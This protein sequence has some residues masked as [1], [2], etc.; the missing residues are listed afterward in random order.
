MLRQLKRHKD[1]LFILVMAAFV[2]L[3]LLPP[4]PAGAVNCAS[5]GTDVVITV[6]CDFPAG[7]YTFTGT[8]T[9]NPGVTVTAL[10]NTGG[11]SG[12]II[13][14]DE[15]RIY[16]TLTAAGQGFTA[17]T[18][19]GAG[20]SGTGGTGAG[21]GGSGGTNTGGGSYGS[22]T[23]PTQLGSGGGSDTND[24]VT[25]ATG[26]G[27]IKLSIGAGTG[28]IVI[29]G[30]ISANGNNAGGAVST[31]AGPGS[32]GSIWIDAP[33]GTITGG[34]AI[35]AVGGNSQASG[36]GVGAGGG[37]IAL[38]YT[39]LSATGTQSANGGTFGSASSATFKS[40][41]AG[42][43]YRKAAA[44]ANG[45]VIYD[46]SN[47]TS[48]APTR[49][50]TTS[51][52]TYDNVTIKNGTNYFIP[53]TFTLNAVTS[54]TGGGTSMPSLTI[55]GTFGAPTA[56]TT[57]SGIDINHEGVVTTL[58]NPT[59][60]NGRYNLDTDTGTFTSGTANRMNDLTVGSGGYFFTE[61]LTKLFLNSLTVNSGGIVSHATNTTSKT[62]ILDVSATGSIT[63]NSGG[64]ISVNARGY[65]GGA[66]GVSGSGPGAGATGGFA[67]GGS[68]GGDGGT[69]SSTGPTGYDSVTAPDDLGS[70]G[71]GDNVSGVGG[72]GGGYVRLT[73]PSGQ[74]ITIA[75]SVTANG[76]NGSAADAGGGAGGTVHISAVGATV[77]GAGTITANGGNSP[78]IEGGG[79]GGGGR[80]AVYASTNSLSNAD[81]YNAAGGATGSGATSSNADGGA[82]SIYTK[83]DAASFGNLIVDNNNNDDPAPTTQVVTSSQTYINVTLKE[84]AEYVIPAT[85][86][87]VVA[88][89][90]FYTSGTVMP[91]LTVNGTFDAPAASMTFNGI[92]IFHNGT[93][94]VLTNPTVTNGR[95]TID[96][97]TSLFSAG[98]ANRVNNVTMGSG[99]F[100]VTSKLSKLFLSTLT[101]NSG[102][103]V[104]HATNTTAKTHILDVSASG[105]ITVNSGASVNVNERGYSGGTSSN[106]GN[107]PGFG[108]DG[109]FG[110]GASHGGNGGNGSVAGATAYDSVTAPS[111][112]GSG[113][114]GDDTGGTG[115]NG[116]GYVRLDAGDAATLTI[117]GS[118]TANGGNGSALDAAG[119]AGGTIHIIATGGTLTGAGTITANGGNSPTIEGGGGGG[120]GRIAV[121]AGTNSLSNGTPY[122]A[123][124]GATGS[125][126]VSTAGDGGAGSIYLKLDAATNGDLI[127]DNNNQGQSAITPQVVTLSQTY[128]NIII[129]E[130]A[131]YSLPNTFSLGLASG[132]TLTG[133]GTVRGSLAIANG[134]TFVGAATLNVLSVD[135]T[136]SGAFSTVTNLTLTGSNYTS[137]GTGT[138]STG[139]TSLT[140]SNATFNHGGTNPGLNLTTL[141]VPSGSTFNNNFNAYYPLSS[142][143]STLTVAGTFMHGSLNR[144]F[145]DTLTVNSGG[146]VTHATNTTTQAYALDI[147]ATTSI[148]V[149]SGGSINVNAKGYASSEGTGQGTDNGFEGQ[150]GGYGGDG[151]DSANLSSGGAAYGSVTQPVDL[152]SG[153]GADGNNATAGGAGGGAIKLTAPTVTIAGTVSTNGGNAEGTAGQ[154]GGGGSGGSIWVVATSSFTG[155]GTITANGGNAPTGTGNG[156][157]GGGGR[158]ALHYTGSLPSQTRQAFGGARGTATG[159]QKNGGA[160]T[161]Y[162][163]SNSQTN[164]DIIVDNNNVAGDFT[165][166]VATAAQTYDNIT[167]RN[168]SSYQVPS[169]FT[170]TLASGGALTAG[171]SVRPTMTVASGG[172]FNPTATTFNFN[173]IDVLNSGTIASVTTLTVT[174]GRFNHNAGANFSGGVASL[175]LASSAIWTDG[176][177]S[178]FNITSLTVPAGTSYTIANEKYYPFASNFGALSVAGTL[179]LQ[180]LA[181]FYVD[182]VTV[183]SGGL[184]THSGNT[185]SKQYVVDIS[186]TSTID[187]QS[188]GSINVDNLGY[189]SDNGTSPGISG[190]NSVAGGGAHGGNGGSVGGGSPIGAGGTAYDLVNQ[191]TDFGSGGGDD[192]L[193]PGANGGAGGG[194]IKLSAASGATVTIAGTVSANGQ[195]GQGTDSG[196]GAGGSIWINAPAATLAGTGTVRARGGSGIVGQASGGGGGGRVAIYYTSGNPYAYTLQIDGGVGGTQ[197]SQ[198]QSGGSG[199]IYLKSASQTNGDLYLD[200]NNRPN[201]VATPQL[202]STETYDKIRIRNLANY[203]IPSAFVFNVASGGTI[204]GG[205]TA[206]GVMTINSGATFNPPSATF[207]LEGLNVTHTGSFGTV[208]DLTVKNAVLTSAGSGFSA[209]LTAFTADTGG[210]YVSSSSS[211][212]LTASGTITVKSGGLL[213][214]ATN[215][216][217][218]HH[219]YSLNISANN[220]DIQSGGSVSVAGKG[221]SGSNGPGSGAPNGTTGGG[222][223]HGGAGGNGSTVGGGGGTYGSISQPVMPGSGGGNDTTSTTVSEGGS[224]GGVIKITLGAT[225]TLNGTLSANGNAGTGGTDMGGGGAGGSIW[226]DVGTATLNANVTA[227]GGVGGANGVPGGGGGGGGRIAA[228]YVVLTGS[229]TSTA[230]GG[231][232]GGSG[233]ATAGANGSLFNQL[234]S[235]IVLVTAPN[236]AESLTGSATTSVTFSSLGASIDHFRISLST[237][238]GSSFGTIITSTAT[239]SPYVWTI[240]NITTTQ[241]R[242]KVEGLDV[243][244]SAV[245]EDSSNADFSITAVST[246][247]P[248]PPAP[249]MTLLAPNGGN[250]FSSGQQT[251]ILWTSGGISSVALSYST[252][253]GSTYTQITSGLSPSA[254]SYTWTVPALS[255]TSTQTI[256]KADGGTVYDTSDAVFTINA[257]PTLSTQPS[258]TVTSPNGGETLSSG[259]TKTVTWTK[260]GTVGNLTL[261]YSKDGGATYAQIAAGISASAGSYAWNVPVESATATQALVRITDGT[262]TDVSDAVFTI[263]PSVSPEAQT[264]LGS[265]GLQAAPLTVAATD[266]GDQLSFSF[267]DEAKSELTTQLF[268]IQDAA[269]GQW[270]VPATDTGT[271]DLQPGGTSAAVAFRRFIAAMLGIAP[272]QAQ[273][274]PVGQYALGTTPHYQT[275][276]QWGTG[277]KLTSLE[278][279]KTYELKA[280]IKPADPAQPGTSVWE[281]AAATPKGQVKFDVSKR[282]VET[283]LDTNPDPNAVSPG[284]TLTYEF[285]IK[286]TG[287][288]RARNVSLVDPFPTGTTYVLGS[289]TSDGA[290]QTDAKDAVDVGYMANTNREA[291]WTWYA[292][293]IGD[294]HVVTVKLRVTALSGGSFENSGSVT[295]N[296]II[297]PAK[298][299]PIRTSVITPPPVCGDLRCEYTRGETF[300]TCNRDCPATCGDTR[301]QAGYGETRTSCAADCVP[302]C[303]NARCEA[304]LGETWSTCRQDCPT[305]CGNRVCQAPYETTASCAADCPAIVCGNRRCEAGENYTSCA[306]DCAAPVVARCGDAKCQYPETYRTCSRDCKA[307]VCGDKQCVFG[308]TTTSCPLDCRILGESEEQWTIRINNYLKQFP[309]S[310]PL[311]EYCVAQGITTQEACDK[312]L[313]DLKQ[314]LETPPTTPVVPVTPVVPATP[315]PPTQPAAQEPPAVQPPPAPAKTETQPDAPPAPI[316][317]TAE[318]E[319]RAKEEGGVAVG[320]AVVS[321][322]TAAVLSILPES[323]AVSVA[324]TLE[325]IGDAAGNVGEAIGDASAAISRTPETIGETPLVDAVRRAAASLP[326]SM[327]A[328]VAPAI[329]VTRETIVAVRTDPVIQTVNR[330]V[331]TP[332]AVTAI[333]VSNGVGIGGLAGFQQFGIFLFTQASLL[334][335]RRK[336]FAYGI[337]Y[338]WANKLPVDLAVV[339]LID[340]VSGRVVGTR[341]TDKL[342]RYLFIA[343]PG[344]FK[345]EIRVNGFAFPS[346]AIVRSGSD[347]PYS[348]LYY[349]DAIPLPQGGVVTKNVPIDPIGDIRGN[350]KILSDALKKQLQ[351]SVAAIGPAM[352]TVSYL[353][354]PYPRQLL[355][356]VV[357]LLLFYVFY[358]ISRPKKPKSWGAVKDEKGSPIKHVIVRIV[359]TKY[360]KVLESQLT[361]AQGRYSFLVG[362][363]VYYLRFE[364]MGYKRVETDPLDFSDAKEPAIAAFDIKLEKDTTPPAALSHAPP[365][366]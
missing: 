253:G 56:S 78:T 305:V 365:A 341:V 27:A 271:V 188:G 189:S 147:S 95:Y 129:R 24:S 178:G 231:A 268:A 7:T 285:K 216:S 347:G 187:V 281:A 172:T 79:G 247:S 259:T 153:G 45:D 200:N 157:G 143:F 299:A 348:D 36:D 14:A 166:Q 59:I 316:Q 62:H 194:L 21:H 180:R 215:T 65:A 58:T 263:A 160:G 214:S 254:G 173:A 181:T 197:G 113:G 150:G 121:Y 313:A 201:A 67:N 61:K 324:P 248:A 195:D 82:G 98:T 217:G 213:T 321:E 38:Y 1:R 107:G 308:E 66:T 122:S 354:T 269:S 92:N 266:R 161:I 344:E 349:G 57:F 87:L 202:L 275:A 140:L 34:G 356:I 198:Q 264:V 117:A 291:R 28:S 244:N 302:R 358:R 164:G 364:K 328:A 134:A 199:T 6:N 16:G 357:H 366:A 19:S 298:P 158:I 225:L 274:A 211:T 37:R 360:N 64:S 362:A 318:A 280:I 205:G 290:R 312:A 125:Q 106:P 90:V 227:N 119:G 163:K 303:G 174:T 219:Q 293:E 256:I 124:G 243:G 168:G 83:L 221:F 242:I 69:G 314:S 141:S 171:G 75:G 334:A 76:G 315:E 97:D 183:S 260:I 144:L 235:A 17:A 114:G 50:V 77:T 135:I 47:R 22:V 159:N 196:G 26:G 48:P 226:Y 108:T 320:D 10:G 252:N 103:V 115:G 212:S 326:A 49:Q 51:S 43:I 186:A 99:G 292:L 284:A 267:S 105:S 70:G 110:S 128:D 208:T 111:D 145:L 294:E 94:G 223:G 18:G 279:E 9:I 39:T 73:V 304:A 345:L 250:V 249:S 109:G 237:D 175:S 255:A 251:S 133:S 236:G 148:V 112:L 63:V 224:G 25:G 276:S 176:G 351:W 156:G 101:V 350:D 342:G 182:S 220:L 72:S 100:L 265:L 68:H 300:L 238:S 71:G 355:A 149:N 104:T 278:G 240:N 239:S 142:S 338:N 32:G 310:K 273:Q 333:A 170:T 126:N 190:S 44:A 288:V 209:G 2:L 52:Q 12:V 33:N 53:D 335:S 241:G 228:Y 74:T 85:F 336:R 339:R 4:L 154:D 132:G 232:K 331:V 35:T 258:L 330:N 277:S 262:T 177:G 325:A 136:N 218:S 352:A 307:P 309:Q 3:G 120:G 343:P 245:A 329:E 165:T 322:A 89:G 306:S 146:I 184:I 192:T 233:T 123:A 20:V 42:S 131:E 185:T 301:C 23:A 155:T 80:V 246:G 93:V 311:P 118:V 41:G 363:N 130:G 138:F 191:P 179:T 116:G 361:D 86:T 222:G 257:D 169:T 96:T 81:P 31:E 287:N 11:D 40:G 295:G 327:E 270:I 13:N 296:G 229:G 340:V 102:G 323:M 283:I 282:I 139:V 319:Q 162:L 88:S 230:T 297:A 151:G 234:N 29:A 203:S 152:G 353:T 207:T 337:V 332:A 137:S 167:I 289:L 210:I 60:L 91:S 84:G 127:V 317:P 206:N 286:N 359:E 30:T 15:F 272:A 54:L 8:L 204:A 5:S 261:S 193:D 346:D 55:T 46:N